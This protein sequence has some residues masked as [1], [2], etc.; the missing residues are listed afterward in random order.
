[1]AAAAMPWLNS[2]DLLRRFVQPAA[3][4]LPQQPLPQQ[5]LPFNPNEPQWPSMK[6]SLPGPASTQLMRELTD[7]QGEH[8]VQFFV[9]Y[10]KSQGNYLVDVDGNVL[11]DLFSQIASAS[12]GYNHPSFIEALTRPSN[13]VAPPDLKGVFTM[14]CGTC[15]NEQAFKVAF[16]AYRAPGCPSLSILSFSNAFHGRTMG[17]TATTHSKW[18]CKLD[19]PSVDWPIADFPRLKYPLDVYAA[20]NRQEENRCLEQVECRIHEYAKKGTDVAGVIIEPIQAE[21]GDNHASPYFFQQLQKICK[22]NGAYFIVDEVQTGGGA[23]GNMWHHQSWNLPESPDVVTFSKKMQT[24]GFYFK[25]ELR[26]TEGY[27][28]FNTWMGDP[29]KVV[30]LEEMLAVIRRDRLMENVVDVGRHL[31]DGLSHL[32]DLYPGQL[33]SARGTGFFCAVN[34]RDTKHRD[35]LVKTLK[36]RGINVGASGPAS[37]RLRPALIFQ[38]HHADIFLDT[39]DSVLHDN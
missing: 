27:R 4:P 31:M 18:S 37:V 21:G 12:L 25:D 35:T 9:D 29:S 15:S 3:V 11:L 19:Y 28:I 30:L 6:T 33:D 32:Q 5:P 22:E 1:M 20:E 39:F 23:T 36:N 26:P 2:S 10:E 34:A 14:G 38:R 8:M 24:G 7:I 13:Q 16:M 17:A